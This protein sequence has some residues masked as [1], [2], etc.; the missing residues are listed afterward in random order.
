MIALI[1]N[2]MPSEDNP[3]IEPAAGPLSPSRTRKLLQTLE[4]RPRK[5]LGQNFLI[6]GNIVRK[7]LQRGEVG[8]G[9]RVVEVGPGLGTLTTALLQSGAEVYAVERDPR[10]ANWLRT[11]L[12]PRYPERLHLHEGDALDEPLAGYPVD[13]GPFKIIANLPYAI[14]TP[15]LER[16]LHG[17]LLPT[18]MVLMLQRETAARFLAEAGTKHFGAIRIFLES[19]YQLQAFEAVAARCFYPVPE[20]DSVLLSLIRLETPYIFPAPLRQVIRAVFTQRRKQL[21]KVL[22]QAAPDLDLT[23]WENVLRQAGYSLQ[24][25]AEAIPTPLWQEMGEGEL[26]IKS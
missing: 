10:L 25:R 18:R 4:H 5:A 11:D 20:V 3:E 17:P 22:R 13:R 2:D 15:W 24:S 9:D 23:G 16:V 26:R 8:E 21:G 14:S 7:S 6:D 12:R 19:T 1:H